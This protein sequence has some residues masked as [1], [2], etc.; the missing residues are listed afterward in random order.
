MLKQMFHRLTGPHQKPSTLTFEE[1]HTILERTGEEAKAELAAGAHEAGILAYLSGDESGEIRSLVAANRAAPHA[2]DLDL[3][4]DE[5]GHVRAELARKIARLIPGLSPRETENLRETSIKV[6]ERLAADSLPL[7]RQI[8]AEEIKS[9]RNVPKS[10]ALR[11]AR[12]AEIAV[13]APIL[14]YSPLLVDEDLI[15]IIAT[16]EIEGVLEAIAKRRNLS[17]EVSDAV[18]AT[19]DIPAVAALLANQS[20]EIRAVT[21]EFVIENAAGIETWHQPLV[22]RPELSLRAVRRISGF[23]ASALLEQLAARHHLDDDTRRFIVG[24]VR[25]RLKTEMIAPQADEKIHE[26]AMAAVAQAIKSKRLDDEFV[27]DAIESEDRP[28]IVIALAALADVPEAHVERILKSG[29]GQLITAFAW[30]ARLAMRTA[31]LLQKD[32]A[33]VASRDLV[34]ARNGVDFP[35]SEDQMRTHLQMVAISPRA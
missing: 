3:S 17:A 11:L 26:R 19:L 22:V 30:H 13:A 32:I 29:N 25:E 2:V 33:R 20:A 9:A 34:P 31:F 1:A 4:E 35:Y 27:T 24:R 8:V 14:E 21:L 23:V 7:V 10:I 5:N 18:V 28:R 12:D 15:E 6:L 16:S